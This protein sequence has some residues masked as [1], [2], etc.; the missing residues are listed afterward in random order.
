MTPREALQTTL[1]DIAHLPNG[2]DERM[3]SAFALFLKHLFGEKEGAQAWLD[4]IG[5]TPNEMR[6]KLEAEPLNDIQIAKF[7]RLSGGISPEEAIA[8]VDRLRRKLEVV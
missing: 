3:G 4:F 7:R 6:S 2:S 5:L 1:D 8:N